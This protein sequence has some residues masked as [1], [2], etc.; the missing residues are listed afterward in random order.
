MGIPENI[1]ALLL[2]YDINQEALARIVGVSQAAVSGWRHNKRPSNANVKKICT[3]FGLEPNDIL[4]D[5]Y[6]LAA[7]ERGE[8]IKRP[9][10]PM[11]AS[12]PAFLPLVRVG[13]MHSGD[14]DECYEQGEEVMVPAEVVQEH[15]NAFVMRN[16]GNCMD[17]VIL[18]GMDGVIDPD[19]PPKRGDPALVQFE[20]GETVLRC[21]FPF[22]D[23]V[24]LSPSSHEEF[25]DIVIRAEDKTPF[26]VLGTLVWRQGAL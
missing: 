11:A 22:K 8:V 6:G 21:Y 14:P 19:I 4:S 24:V 2:R 9:G 23:M 7:Q 10:R 26:K 17:K 16:N 18:D 12:E 20:G 25:E 15:P 1:D 13:T 3:Y 5:T